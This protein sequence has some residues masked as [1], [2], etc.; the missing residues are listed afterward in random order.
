MSKNKVGLDQELENETET[1]HKI[2]KDIAAAIIMSPAALEEIAQ[3]TINE[4]KE[5]KPIELVVDRLTK[6]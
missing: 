6:L 4:Y 3:G 1:I 2:A 5:V